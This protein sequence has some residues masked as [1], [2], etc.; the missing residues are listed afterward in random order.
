M[1]KKT[2]FS[3]LAVASVLAVGSMA[4]LSACGG[5]KTPEKVSDVIAA[6]N[7]LPSVEQLSLSDKSKVKSARDKYNALKNADKG[8]VTNLDKLDALEAQME[9]GL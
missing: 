3:L 2:K 8:L 1:R 9:G 5:E 4:F 7:A 6:V